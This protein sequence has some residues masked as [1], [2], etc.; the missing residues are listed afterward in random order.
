M[1]GPSSSALKRALIEQYREQDFERRNYMERFGKGENYWSLKGKP[2]WN[3]ICGNYREN[4][5]EGELQGT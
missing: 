1:W 4:S 3:M 2:T 5:L